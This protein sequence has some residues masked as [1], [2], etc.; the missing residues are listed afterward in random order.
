[1]A[2]IIIQFDGTQEDL[3]DF[4]KAQ[5][6]VDGLETKDQFFQ[7]KVQ[8]FVFDSVKSLRIARA[9]NAARRVEEAKVINF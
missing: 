8:E 4:C 9:V 6:Y 1:M 3:D 5:F 7:R 2:K